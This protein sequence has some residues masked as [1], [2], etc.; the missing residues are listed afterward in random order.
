MRVVSGNR[1]L[2]EN[3]NENWHLRLTEIEWI[4]L[5]TNLVIIYDWLVGYD[6][7]NGIVFLLSFYVNHNCMH[8]NIVGIKPNV[9]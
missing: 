7:E 2:N 3:E 9:L 4:T 5:W 8:Q 1:I 6:L